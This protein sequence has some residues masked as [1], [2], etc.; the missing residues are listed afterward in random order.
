MSKPIALQR[1]RGIIVYRNGALGDTIVT[2]PVLQNLR[3]AFPHVP[4]HFV[5][6]KE[7]GLL[8]QT[9]GLTDS[10]VSADSEWARKWFAG[11]AAGMR[12][13]VE[14]ADAL[15]AFTSE[16]DE[17]K[18]TARGAGFG[19]VRFQSPTLPANTTIHIVDHLFSALNG[20]IDGPLERIPSIRL[21][22]EQVVPARRI[23]DES[24]LRSGTP[25]VFIHTGAS[26]RQR[27]WPYAVDFARLLREKTGCTPVLHMGP[28]EKENAALE[29]HEVAD[30]PILGPFTVLEL[31]AALSC[32]AA[33]VGS[34]TG[35]SHLSA[36]LGIPTF[37]VFGGGDEGRKNAVVWSPRGQRV[38]ALRCPE[39]Q[40]WPSPEQVVQALLLSGVLP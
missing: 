15:I 33:Y 40:D 11:D 10:V 36:A 5:A 13:L 26:S 12:A 20:L 6:S 4:L 19:F 9:C 23:L 27:V 29:P 37:T 7:V 24:G 34:D 22:R 35:P 2:F 3:L 21:P 38:H 25:Y 1:V 31:A 32:A 17:L 14:G 18:E 39:G 16:D 28:I 8:A 30:M